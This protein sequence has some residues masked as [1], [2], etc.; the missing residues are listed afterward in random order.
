MAFSDLIASHSSTEVATD[1]GATPAEL[2]QG[3]PRPSPP[4][5]AAESAQPDAGDTMAEKRVSLP[6]P[7][8]NNIT[9]LTENLPNEPILPWHRF[10]SPWLEKDAS[11]PALLPPEPPPT[12]PAE[13]DLGEQL[14]LALE[15]EVP[16]EDSAP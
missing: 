5:E 12:A 3:E 9:V 13:D 8:I 15:A 11:N 14:S 6:K 4:P 16:A 1:P 2:P 7:D 10:T